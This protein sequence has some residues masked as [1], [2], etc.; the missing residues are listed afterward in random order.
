MERHVITTVR[1]SKRFPNGLKSYVLDAG[2]N[3][4]YT[5]T[6]YRFNIELDREVQGMGEVSVLNGPLC[7]NID[8]V[9]DA[10]I[11]PPLK[12]DMRLILSP[13]GA[14]NVTQWM[15]FIEYRPAIVLIS[16]DGKPEVIRM[17]ETLDDLVANER[18]P[19]RLKL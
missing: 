7:M 11:L 14:Y 15:Q 17:A 9:D 12:R 8:I 18:L 19:D 10:A 13:V 5:S 1:S 4:L 6:W 3:L 16:E 2:V